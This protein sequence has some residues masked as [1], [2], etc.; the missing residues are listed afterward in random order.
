MENLLYNLE[1]NKYQ[2]QIYDLKGSKLNRYSKNKNKVLLDTNFKE[3]FEGEP[4]VLDIDVYNLFRSAILNDSLLLCKIRVID[5]SL[6]VILINEKE[7][8]T[9]KKIK[10]G[11]LDYFRKYT[12]DKKIETKFKKLMNY[13]QDPTIISPENYKKR[14]D[15]IISS[16]FIGSG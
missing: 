7:Y 6:L 14:F 5:Y 15:E 10:F 2:L 1:K 8:E 9:E 3:D 11:I 12:W 13:F 16:Y 4:L